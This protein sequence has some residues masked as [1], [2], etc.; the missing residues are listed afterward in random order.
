MVDAQ[1]A[2]VPGATATLTSNQGTKTFVTD[3]SGRFFAPFLTPGNYSVKVELSG[4][5]PVEQKNINV[6]LGQRV[7]LT[8][9]TLK[10]GGLEEVVEVIGSAPV[11][12]T[13]ST[14]AGAVLDT[15]NA[16]QAA[17]G[18]QLHR[19]ASTSLPGVSDS[20][21]VGSSNPSVG[22][23]TGLE[24]NYVVDG[25]N[26]TNTGYGAVGS[27]SIVFGSLGSGVTTDFIK[28]TQVKTAGFE[29]EYGQST[30]GVINVVTQSGTNAFHG[31]VY[32]F[33]R[34]SGLESDWQQLDTPDGTVNTTATENTDFGVTLGGPLV[35]DKIFFFGAFNPQY[36]NRTFRSPP[37]NAAF[38]QR[39][40][41]GRAQAADHSYAGKLTWQTSSN[42]RFDLSAFGDPAQRRPRSAARRQPAHAGPRGVQRADASTAATTRSCATTA[43]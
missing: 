6:R 26:I 25:V 4:F 20:G 30:G 13:S 33:F 42:H 10:V 18:P 37:T 3:S 1:G 9:L 39:A 38:P 22:G 24:N 21:R 15:D 36:Q 35:K 8:G 16:Q 31:S 7:E 40:W 34:P 32:G 29:A 11:I 5:S 27:Y 28:E 41:G 17:G 43:S 19:H 2:P 12:D 23:A 14:T